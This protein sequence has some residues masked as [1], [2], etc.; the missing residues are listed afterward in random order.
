MKSAPDAGTIRITVTE[1]GR[2]LQK[3]LLHEL[4]FE[5]SFRVGSGHVHSLSPN[6]I[7]PTHSN[8]RSNR[9]SYLND[10]SLHLPGYNSTSIS[11]VYDKSY[12]SRS[13]DSEYVKLPRIDFKPELEQNAFVRRKIEKLNRDLSRLETRS[14]KTSKMDSHP[15]LQSSENSYNQS[16][17]QHGQSFN[18]VITRRPELNDK[19]V[20]R[21]YVK[22]LHMESGIESL[23][24]RHERNRTMIDKTQQQVEKKYNNL[25]KFEVDEKSKPPTHLSQ[26]KNHNPDALEALYRQSN[27]AHRKFGRLN[28]RAKK[29]YQP[30]WSHFQDLSRKK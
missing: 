7:E 16:F 12:R 24:K 20:V 13:K 3:V 9:V 10:S 11:H 22:M 15:L 26:I 1:R 14:D 4:K 27:Y 17:D 25:K 5:E 23:L 28:N 19:F 6:L 8:T 29:V 21:N 30:Y 18:N 2:Q